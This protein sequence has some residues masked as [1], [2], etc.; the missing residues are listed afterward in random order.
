MIR[1]LLIHGSQQIVTVTNQ[2]G[3]KFLR[4]ENMQKIGIQEAIDGVGLSLLI[5]K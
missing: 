1:R 5:E 4:G 3:E 2:P